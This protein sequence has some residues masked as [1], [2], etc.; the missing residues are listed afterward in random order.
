MPTNI[1]YIYIYIC[2]RKK[3]ASMYGFPKVRYSF[4]FHVE[5][6]T[7]LR[8]YQSTFAVTPMNANRSVEKKRRKR[9]YS[10]IS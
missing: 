4:Y 5:E 1:F 8:I 10:L 6:N 9:G 2:K 7:A 3:K